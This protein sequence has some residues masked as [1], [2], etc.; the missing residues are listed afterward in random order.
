MCRELKCKWET[1]NSYL[2]KMGIQYGGNQSGKGIK[3]DPK[4]KP[5][6]EYLKS[7]NVESAKIKIKLLREGYKEPKCELC[8]ISS[9]RGVDLVL[10]LHHKDG[11]HYNNVIENFQLL[12]PNCHSIQEIHKKSRSIYNS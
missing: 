9:W 4:Y 5:L 11:D 12:C 3:S 2:Q 8:G 10:E 1:L 6:I 7:S